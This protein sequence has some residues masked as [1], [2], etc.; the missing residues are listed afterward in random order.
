ML[1]LCSYLSRFLKFIQ[2]SAGSQFCLHCTFIDYNTVNGV[3][4]VH[5][6]SYSYDII[7]GTVS[8]Q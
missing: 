7:E 1:R 6:L 4:I 2:A 5:V 8:Y 3:E